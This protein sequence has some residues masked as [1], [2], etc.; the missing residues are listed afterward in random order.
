MDLT[1]IPFNVPVILHSICK[2]KNLQNPVGTIQ[3]RCLADNRDVYEQIVLRH[4]NDKVAIQS[5]RNDRF[6]RVCANGN[7]TFDSTHV[8]EQ[9]LFNMESDSTCSLFFVSCF[10]GNTLHDDEDMIKCVNKNRLESE[11]WRIIEPHTPNTGMNQLEYQHHVL[12]GRD[13]QH[14]ILELAKGGKT[15]DEIEQIVTRLFDSPTVA[16]P[17]HK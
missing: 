8:S 16:I 2:R 13:R 3:A 9:D 14:L 15:P 17:L 10:T 11:A 12:A 6:L 7:C 4:I 1:D 5:V